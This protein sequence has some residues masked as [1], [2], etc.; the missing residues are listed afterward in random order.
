M[1]NSLEKTSDTTTSDTSPFRHDNKSGIYGYMMSVEEIINTAIKQLTTN[2]LYDCCIDPLEFNNIP[3]Y[4]PV[5]KSDSSKLSIL[6]LSRNVCS[7]MGK[8]YKSDFES[9]YDFLKFN[10]EGKL[11]KS[12]L[13]EINSVLRDGLKQIQTEIEDLEMNL[14]E[15]EIT[16]ELKA[17]LKKFSLALNN[18]G[19]EKSHMWVSISRQLLEF[20]QFHAD[21]AAFNNSKCL[22]VYITA[23]CLYAFARLR[24][25]RKSKEEP[26]EKQI[27]RV[28]NDACKLL[29]K[30][31][32]NVTYHNAEAS[33]KRDQDPYYGIEEL[34]G[35]GPV[36]IFCGLHKGLKSAIIQKFACEDNQAISFDNE[37]QEINS[38]KLGFNKLL[39]LLPKTFLKHDK[40]NNINII[41]DVRIPFRYNFDSSLNIN[42]VWDYRRETW[43]FKPNEHCIYISPLVFKAIREI[44]VISAVI[45]SDEVENGVFERPSYSK[46]SK[47]FERKLFYRV[48]ITSDYEKIIENQEPWYVV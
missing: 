11:L 43:H 18:W 13:N 38:F 39:V 37:S 45:N 31:L 35:C 26:I 19:M 29:Q 46:M 1:G 22:E 33:F 27:Q 2:Q 25:E 23:L 8:E 42:R 6:N 36:D 15:N 32:Q 48:E 30:S 14:S 47:T 44:S 3:S 41:V 16:E 5:E 17:Q 34:P 28:I 20:I 21:G 10:I 9:I 24:S 4:S 40:E 7:S 12:K